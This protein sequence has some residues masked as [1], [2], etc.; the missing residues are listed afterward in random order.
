MVTRQPERRCIRMQQARI[1]KQ[2]HARAFCRVDHV[3]MLRGT[4]AEIVRR[5]Q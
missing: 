1:S 4:L 5:N 3:H 2:A